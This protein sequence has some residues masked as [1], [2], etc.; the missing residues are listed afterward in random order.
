MTRFSISM[1]GCVG[2]LLCACQGGADSVDDPS[3]RPRD[4]ANSV[5]ATSGPTA[6]SLPESCADTP[7]AA[8]CCEA[9][10]IAVEGTPLSD[11]L[12]Q[13]GTTDAHCVLARPGDDRVLMGAGGGRALLGAGDD[14]F[15]GGVEAE[16]VVA[17]LGDDTIDG[18]RGNDELLGEAGNDDINGGGDDDFIDPGEGADR[19][20]AGLGD[21]TVVIRHLCEVE[22]GEWLDG[23]RGEDV[24][25][26]PVPVAA[27]VEAGAS[28]AGF[29]QIVVEP[30]PCGSTCAEQPECGEHGACTPG[31]DGEAACECEEGH[32]GPECDIPC[33]EGQSC[34]LELFVHGNGSINGALMRGGVLFEASDE[35]EVE[36]GLKQWLATHHEIVKID[37]TETLD[38]FDELVAAESSFRERGSLRTMN[39]RQSYR[40]HRIFGP[41]QQMTATLAPG[42]GVISFAGTVADPREDYSGLADPITEAMAEAAILSRWQEVG[43]VTDNVVITDLELVAVPQAKAMG[44]FAYI[45]EFSTPSSPA[46][47]RFG[48]VVVPAVRDAGGGPLP[49][50]LGYGLVRHESPDQAA[51]VDVLGSPFTDDTEEDTDTALWSSLPT[52][53]ALLGSEHTPGGVD[54]GIKLGNSLVQMYD[55]QGAKWGTAPAPLVNAT[56]VFDEPRA[57]GTPW[58]AQNSY[59]HTQAAMEL[60]RD[61]KAGNWDHGQKSLDAGFDAHDAARLALWVNIG[62]GSCPSQPYCYTAISYPVSAVLD[63]VDHE[64]YRASAQDPIVVRQPTIGMVADNPAAMVHE[65]GHFF[66]DHSGA[67]MMSSGAPPGNCTP[68]P[69]SFEDCVPGCHPDTTDESPTLKETI[70]NMFAASVMPA[71]YGDMTYDDDCSTAFDAGNWGGDPGI[72]PLSP[73][74][75]NN[76]FDVKMFSDTRPTSPQTG[77]DYYCAAAGGYNQTPVMQAWWSLVYGQVCEGQ[78]PWTC[79][80][81]EG[82]PNPRDAS[83]RA[84]EY[85]LSVS[86]HQWYKMFVENIGV[87][88]ACEYGPDVY[89]DYVQVMSNHELMDPNT[90]PPLCPDVCGDG[91]VGPNE[92]CDDGNHINGDGCDADC[93][94]EGGGSGGGVDGEPCEELLDFPGG[95]GLTDR[96][97]GSASNVE[98]ELYYHWCGLDET[99][100]C[101]VEDENF[102]CRDCFPEKLPGCYCESDV[103]CMTLG[104]GAKCYGPG[105]HGPEFGCFMPNEAPVY[106]CEAACQTE[107]KVCAWDP[108][109]FMGGTCFNEY[110]LEPGP[111]FACERDVGVE[112]FPEA[113]LCY[114]PGEPTCDQDGE[115]CDGGAGVCS[116]RWSGQ[117][118][119]CCHEDCLIPHQAS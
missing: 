38:I 41:E 73:A 63:S 70:P 35:A 89:A 16:L 98:E 58:Q 47:Q 100:T 96:P 59:L 27:L 26:T 36:Q 104:N 113:E 93:F 61:V 62:A 21:D 22:R 87:Y 95:T 13:S 74:C 55:A 33:E 101:V 66:D 39:F 97:W 25:I 6:A 82:L 109:E 119:E 9:G 28:V 117:V 42:Q 92:E 57:S 116:L 52:G 2:A 65:V 20:D 32:T 43:D 54:S 40:G 68:N 7:D 1:L 86:N 88:Y 64:Y 75:V 44:W 79:S 106:A 56:G 76:Q 67:G 30:D 3:P 72:P 37:P 77:S 12:D 115:S 23:S 71:L 94:S 114:L 118:Y 80:D 90:P 19:V 85:A 112:C 78:A 60:I 83:L 15:F 29:E 51:N 10:Q 5:A 91:I 14:S 50:V 46:P 111:D 8:I 69:Q 11:V 108:G 110:C 81:I 48:Y 24:L 4:V 18:G 31:P 84:L 34:E 53:G 99:K 102:V 103:E 107:G 49:S 105:L 17:G 45:E